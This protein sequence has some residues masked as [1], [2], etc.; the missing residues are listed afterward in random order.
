MMSR[1]IYHC[2]GLHPEVS[3]YSGQLWGALILNQLQNLDNYTCSL[4]GEIGLLSE[5]MADTLADRPGN[6]FQQSNII[7]NFQSEGFDN[8][9]IEDV[10][11]LPSE[12]F[13]ILFVGNIGNFKILTASLKQYTNCII[14]KACNCD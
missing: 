3:L 10:R 6:K 8:S 7:N 12:K 5:Y 11:R 4:V 2:M 9:P 13:V 1:L 14:W